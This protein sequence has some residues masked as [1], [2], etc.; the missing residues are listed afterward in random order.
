MFDM[1]REWSPEDIVN[2]LTAERRDLG[3][4][5]TEL[6]IKLLSE[7]APSAV[8]SITNLALYCPDH[9]TRLAAAKFIVE[10]ALDQAVKSQGGKDP[11]ESLLAECVK[12][13]IEPEDFSD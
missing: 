7:H 12:S 11:F 10:S 2:S 8:S 4:S 1:R 5:N 9:R 6:T 3:L 13:G